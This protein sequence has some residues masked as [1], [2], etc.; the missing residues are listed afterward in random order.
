MTIGRH[1]PLISLQALGSLLVADVVS[2]GIR[3]LS[4]G[5][6]APRRSASEP[7]RAGITRRTISSHPLNLQNDHGRIVEGGHPSRFA[8][9]SFNANHVKIAHSSGFVK[10]EQSTSVA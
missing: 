2:G 7:I 6:S 8:L 9:D 1:P 4:F 3:P 10:Q 5:A